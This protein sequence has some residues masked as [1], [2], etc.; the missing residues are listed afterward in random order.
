[1]KIDKNLLTLSSK[2]TSFDRLSKLLKTEVNLDVS[3]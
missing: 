3:S 1:M 2:R